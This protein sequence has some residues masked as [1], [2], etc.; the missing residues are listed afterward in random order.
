MINVKD[1]IQSFVSYKPS[2]VE[3]DIKLDANESQRNEILLSKQLQLETI[4]RYPDH[5]TVELRNA[6]ANRFDRTMEEVMVGSG[7]S[8]L[9][10]LVVKTFVNP[11][12]VVLS[13]EPSFVMYKK[14]TMI[15]GG[16]YKSV[17]VNEQYQLD[18][19]LFIQTAN[20]LQPKVT[21]LCTPNN[22]TG[23]LIPKE[24]VLRII[25]EIPGIIVVDEA[26]M[27]FANESY[28]VVPFINQYPNL[29]V[30]RTFSKAYAL[31][32]ARLGYFIANSDMIET[33][34][35]AKTPYAVTA[36]SQQLG[37]LA[38]QDDTYLKTN[39]A[40]VTQNRE[41]LNNELTRLG[42]TTF[43]SYG[44][45]IFCLYTKKDLKQE[46]EKK[47]I[48]IRGFGSGTYR[49]TIGTKTELVAL[50]KALEEIL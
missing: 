27:E 48:L 17:T 4:N 25:Q 36:I 42:I 35:L 10:E 32:G 23:Y 13:V 11:A 43:P 33:L 3:Y 28:S 50:I 49:I 6:I 20:E 26:Y 34:F 44:N 31:A 46:L 16:T 2:T 12:D 18:V 14:Y 24:D 40:E 8:E 37:L 29:I 39:V 45:F 1:S 38:L 5:Y 21:F 47:R 22:P 15:A 7:S 41:Y 30:N 19:D 9:L